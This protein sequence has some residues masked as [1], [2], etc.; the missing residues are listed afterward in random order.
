MLLD[1]LCAT[2]ASVPVDPVEE[3]YVAVAVCCHAGVRPI[4]SG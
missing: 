2:I 4:P 1:A 3:H